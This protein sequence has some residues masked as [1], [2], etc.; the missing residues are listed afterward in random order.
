[1]NN[2]ILKMLLVA[3]ALGGSVVILAFFIKK[4]T[5]Q[6]SIPA[7]ENIS[8]PRE[9]K[10]TGV[11]L[12]RQTDEIIKTGDFKRCDKIKDETYKNVCVNNIALALAK[13]TKDIS[14]C[15][16]VDNVLVPR[17]MCE[18]EVIFGKSLEKED[19]N[20]CQETA[21]RELKE[22]CEQSFYLRLAL[23]KN[24]S[25]VCDGAG[26]LQID[27]CHNKYAVKTQFTSSRESFNCQSIRGIEAR[28]DCEKIKR[29]KRIDEV[30]CSQLKTNLFSSYCVGV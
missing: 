6:S 1:M 25:G 15:Q 28:A 18:Q 4:N 26:T 10:K 5:P 14:Y 8:M 11:E 21:G 9:T 12:Q 19:V 27:E 24:D 2:P 23:K 17:D 20:V 13:E 7:R 22:S 29:A 3:V 16:K 30:A